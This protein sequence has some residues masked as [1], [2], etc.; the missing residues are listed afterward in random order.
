MWDPLPYYVRASALIGVS[1]LTIINGQVVDDEPCVFVIRE[2][3]RDSE[4][5][6]LLLG[7]QADDVGDVVAPECSEI[8]KKTFIKIVCCL[9]FLIFKIWCFDL[10]SL[11][12]QFHKIQMFDLLY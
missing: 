4:L 1:D 3:T 6:K 2:E 11:F 9:R 12:C 5:P 8:W 7:Q 10:R